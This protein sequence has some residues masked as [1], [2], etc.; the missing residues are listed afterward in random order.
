M[1][2]GAP[3]FA[4]VASSSQSNREDSPRLVQHLPSRNVRARAPDPKSRH[5]R[6][7]R[8]F[9]TV[10]VTLDPAVSTLHAWQDVS[11][12][13]SVTGVTVLILCL[14]VYLAIDRALSP[15]SAIVAGFEST[16]QRRARLSAAEVSAH[17]AAADQRSGEPHGQRARSHHVGAAGARTAPRHCSGR[18]SGDILRASCTT[19]SVKALLRSTPSPRRSKH[20]AGS[21]CP[22]LSPE[23]RS[24]SDIAH[25]D[26]GRTTQY[27]S[28]L[29]AGRRRGN[30]TGRKPEVARRG[31][32]Q[33]ARADNALRH[34]GARAT[35]TRFRMPPP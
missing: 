9:G 34:V 4:P 32:E 18:M 21:R 19:S 25:E 7:A 26:D 3:W 10:E 22:E 35:S 8:R 5:Q 2:F 14:L 27:A 23:A 1:P 16:G 13:A 33:T 15:T 31:M 28:A 29:A 6:A 17:R 20:V 11:R 12:I 30:R 24:L